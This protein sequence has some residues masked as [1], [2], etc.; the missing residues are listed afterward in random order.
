MTEL[1]NQKHQLEAGLDLTGAS[2]VDAEISRLKNEY[3]DV[4]FNL[5]QFGTGL[6]EQGVTGAA[7]GVADTLAFLE[8][9][10]TKP[11]DYVMT[12]GKS[13]PLTDSG[14][15]RRLQQDITAEYETAVEKHAANVSAGGTAAQVVNE[16]GTATVAA[17][18]QAVLAM[19]SGGASAG[20]QATNAGKGLLSTVGSVADKAVKNPAFWSS[21]MQM[22]GSGYEEAKARGA[23]EMAATLEALAAGTI[24]AMVEV[25]GGIETLPGEL[26]TGAFTVRKWIET[27]VDEGKEEVVQGVIS[28]GLQTLAAQDNAPIFGVSDPNAVFNPATAAQ[29][30]A[31]GFV[32]GGIL[33]GTQ[34]LTVNLLNGRA[35]K[36]ELSALGAQVRSSEEGVSRL[37]HLAETLPE[38][39]TAKKQAAA[40][41]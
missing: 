21:F 3:K 8:G 15:F 1:E 6:V 14:M 28:R 5:G 37:L 25:G 20:L 40:L 32:V 4:A 35:T 22:T 34:G 17:V 19:L 13:T 33:G 7:K 16:L 23:S 2:Q 30:F 38:G 9:L 24:N 29:E 12:G 11:I 26:Q 10:V 18:P 41:S 36:A 27:M 39:S 31:G